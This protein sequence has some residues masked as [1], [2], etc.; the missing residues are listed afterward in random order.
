[1][2]WKSEGSSEAASFADGMKLFW[3]KKTVQAPGGT[4]PR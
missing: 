4:Y 1:M 3:L 2:T